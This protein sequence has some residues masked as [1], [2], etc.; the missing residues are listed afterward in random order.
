[1]DIVADAIKK[2]M[3][4]IDTIRSYVIYLNAGTG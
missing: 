2:R 3:I 1:M 4:L